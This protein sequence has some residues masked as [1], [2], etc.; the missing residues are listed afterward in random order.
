VIAVADEVLVATAQIAATL[1][2]LLLVGVLFFAETGLRQ[3]SLF[4][5]QPAAYLRSGTRFILLLYSL[6]LGLSLALLVLEPAWITVTFVVLGIAIIGA[7]VSFTLRARDLRRVMARMHVASLWIAWPPVLVTLALPWVTEG[8]N[9]GREAFTASILL[10]GAFAFVGTAS[11]VLVAFDLSALE[12]EATT[13]G[14][15]PGRD[16]EPAGGSE[17]GVPG[18]DPG[19]GSA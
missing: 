8:L 10:S 9:P 12:K 6:A 13:R 15:P 16:R 17:D 18:A 7:L 14:A 2:G 1:I 19:T 11:L 3:L 4:G 5:P